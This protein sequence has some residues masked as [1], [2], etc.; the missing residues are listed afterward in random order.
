MTAI[1]RGDKIV[2]TYR[3]IKK[4]TSQ[5]YFFLTQATDIPIIIMSV[6]FPALRKF[7]PILALFSV[8]CSPTNL[9]SIKYSQVG[10]ALSFCK[11]L[12]NHYAITKNEEIKIKNMRMCGVFFFTQALCYNYTYQACHRRLLF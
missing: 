6:S 5:G 7:T 8:F 10:I 1:T 9:L 3:Y 12:F 2:S 11:L 4:Y